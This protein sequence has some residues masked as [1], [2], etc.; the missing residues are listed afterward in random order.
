MKKRNK[1]IVFALLV[2]FVFGFTITTN[3]Q[4]S[5]K[6]RTLES[7]LPGSEKLVPDRMFIPFRIN[8]SALDTHVA[9]LGKFTVLGASAYPILAP[10]PYKCKIKAIQARINTDVGDSTA[11]AFYIGKSSDVI[12]DTAGRATDRTGLGMACAGFLVGDTTF[13]DSIGTSLTIIT[14]SGQDTIHPQESIFIYAMEGTDSA[15]TS[16]V[17]WDDTLEVVTG[18]F[19]IEVL[20]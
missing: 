16:A 9:I 20:E 6:K 2:T 18:T 5:R 17:G 10:F 12:F 13:V 1:L 15:L 19:L 11:I 4:S 8:S 3:A 7:I 14:T